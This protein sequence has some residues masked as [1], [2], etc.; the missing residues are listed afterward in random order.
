MGPIA[1]VESRWW[2]TG[3]QG[4]RQLFEAVAAIH[5]ENPSAIYYDMFADRSSLQTVL[6]ARSQDGVSEVIYVASHGDAN[7]ISPT[8]TT[9]ISR[10]EFRNIFKNCNAGGQIKGLF[11]GTCHTGNTETARFLLQDPGTKLE[12]VAGYSNTVDWVDGSAID[13]V[14][15]SKLTELYLSN[16]S[17]RK[18]KLSPRKMAHEAAT[19]LV[20][21]ITGAHTKYGFNIYF[22]ENHKITSMFS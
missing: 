1:V 20:A 4:V 13:M 16:R 2:R 14:F 6:R 15:V 17:R 3:N 10:T 22:H 11:L 8:P 9:A 19:R 12:W 7:C 5:Y 21:L 18:D